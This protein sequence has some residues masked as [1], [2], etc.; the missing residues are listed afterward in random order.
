MATKQL[1]TAFTQTRTILNNLHRKAEEA[2]LKLGYLEN[3]FPRE[4]KDY[5]GLSKFL[6]KEK[7]T[8]LN[9]LLIAAT[10]KKGSELTAVERGNVTNKFLLSTYP[11]SSQTTKLKKG[12]KID[13]LPAELLKFYKTPE[14]SLH[15]YIR[16]VIT[17]TEKVSFFGQAWQANV[18]AS[19]ADVEKSIG[20]IVNDL[21]ERGVIKEGEQVAELSRLLKAR[22]IT[23]ET[24]PDQWVQNAKN[25]TYA[26]TLG[27]PISAA[28]QF[29]DL[30]LA[31]YKT[32]NLLGTLQSA[33]TQ[34]MNPFTKN[35]IRL[36]DYG[37][38]DIA[39]EF[40]SNTKSSAFMRGAFKWGGFR[41]VDR[42]GKETLLNTAYKNYTKAV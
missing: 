39:E 37:F 9:N 3:Y 11:S 22:F 25:I 41:G 14:E 42:I 29:G 32:K 24:A 21:L 28:T 20:A 35:K 6:G 4:I 13:V 27:N 10:K 36:Q 15:G 8:A 33:L 2:G 12:R 40:A 38:I 23:G 7:K 30:F 34:S 1:S 16:R 19:G 31:A 18:L 26:M 17:E 5:A